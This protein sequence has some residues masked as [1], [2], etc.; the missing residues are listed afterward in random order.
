MLKLARFS[1]LSLCALALAASPVL[2]Q[3]AY[4]TQPIRMVVGFPPGGI[5]D[6]VARAVASEASVE[7]GQTI[8]VENR[9]GAG[10]TIA[11]DVVA[12]AKADGYTLL[13]QDLTTHAI[14]ASLYKKLP[15][16][17]I[18]DF[19][20]VA[21]VSSTPLLLV[22]NASSPVK[23]VQELNSR[24]HEKPDTYFYGSSGNGTIIHLASEMMNKAVK[25]NIVHIPYKGSAPLVA[26]IISGDIEYAF[27]S[28][29]PAITQVNA[30][31]LRALAV[32]TPDRVSALPDVPT[33]REAGVPAAE[34]TLYSGV[35]G[36]AGMPDEIVARLNEA[37]GK[38]V[39]SPKVIQTFRNLGAEP[40][41]AP[42]AEI[43]QLLQSE[44]SR[45]GKVVQE[46][47]IT[48]D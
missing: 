18:K 45:Y 34:L 28:M 42:P 40:L 22:I 35:L 12:R 20:P 46:T 38:A 14:N 48:I 2:A 17:T 4:P 33:I 21:M 30:G 5:S 9:P 37:F 16:D 27:S 44:I 47:G 19:T 23:T 43:A 15:Y 26:S 25:N 11:S 36:P 32:S 8:V 7:L 10:T 6:V 3:S 31:K 24:I 39:Q 13:F 41:N 29:P 1:R